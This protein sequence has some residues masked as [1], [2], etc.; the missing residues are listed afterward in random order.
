[1]VLLNTG[2]PVITNRILVSPNI[3]GNHSG[4]KWT[5]LHL[6]IKDLTLGTL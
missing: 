5:G 1:M 4:N 3:V 6:A 2:S